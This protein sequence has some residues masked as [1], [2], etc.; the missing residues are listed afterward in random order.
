[1]F[2]FKL[3][4][5]KTAF[6]GR[7]LYTNE[8]IAGLLPIK[9]ELVDT[10]FL[11]Y[12]LAT[13]DYEVATGHAAKGKTLNLKSMS[14]LMIPLPPIHQQKKIASALNQRIAAQERAKTAALDQLDAIEAMRPALLRQ[15]FNG[16]I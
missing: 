11:K 15:A 6:A 9:Q 14:R 3:S 12:A 5:G 7:D 2:S 4:I 16:A 8:A 10:Y 13:V 1:M